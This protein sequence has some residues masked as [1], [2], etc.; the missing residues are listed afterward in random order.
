MT[1]KIMSVPRQLKAEGGRMFSGYASVFG[2]VDKH[3]DRIMPGAFAST[4]AERRPKMLYQHEFKKPIGVWTEC[5][6]DDHGLY[7]E[8]TLADTTLGREVYNL[9]SM[10]A[11]ESLSV[12]FVGNDKRPNDHGGNDIHSCELFEISVVTFPANTAALIAAVKSS[13]APRTLDEL[14]D[15]YDSSLTALHMN[16]A[17]FRAHIAANERR[18]TEQALE[19]RALARQAES[20]REDVAGAAGGVLPPECFGAL[21]RQAYARAGMGARPWV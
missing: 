11:I 6:E 4:L 2:N 7:V 20:L 8:G 9:L 14:I 21:Q 10:G 1:T 13:E 16:S 19:L 17:A 15:R 12:A 3:G 18:L 5:R